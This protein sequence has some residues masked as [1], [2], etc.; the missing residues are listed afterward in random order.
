MAKTRKTLEPPKP[1]EVLGA[2]FGYF[3]VA[4]DVPT[5]LRTLGLP[6]IIPSCFKDLLLRINK[7]PDF[8]LLLLFTICTLLLVFWFLPRREEPEELSEQDQLASAVAALRRG[9]LLRVVRSLGL[10][11]L[12]EKVLDWMGVGLY[13]TFRKH[14]TWPPDPTRSKYVDRIT[15]TGGA[16]V[17]Y[18][19]GK[20]FCKVFVRT[21]PANNNTY[22]STEER[23]PNFGDMRLL[24]V[25]SNFFPFWLVIHTLKRAF[26][27]GLVIALIFSGSFA[28][29]EPQRNCGP[30]P[31]GASFDQNCKLS[32]VLPPPEALSSEHQ[33]FFDLH[34]T[35]GFLEAYKSGKC[36]D[37]LKKADFH[38]AVLKKVRP[39]ILSNELRSLLDK[40]SALRS[41]IDAEMIASIEKLRER[42]HS[43]AEIHHWSHEKQWHA[44]FQE[45][46]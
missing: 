4:K 41:H 42:V 13:G 28:R 6:K 18:Q 26:C 10:V 24:L 40:I 12:R 27:C 33:V 11:L 43:L 5:V 46:Q 32:P 34:Q 30:V 15:Y 2:F 29:A 38:L 44:D 17:E 45:C 20:N 21:H 8:W 9:K 35:I 19:Y 39:N 14:P 3:A 16:G 36:I 1:W 7:H 23:I 31:P 22:G 37:G 25:A